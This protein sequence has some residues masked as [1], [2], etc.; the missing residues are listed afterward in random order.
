MSE[1]EIMQYLIT[2][3][4]IAKEEWLSTTSGNASRQYDAMIEA[5]QRLDAFREIVESGRPRP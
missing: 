3:V 5:E 2:A 4:C 1:Q